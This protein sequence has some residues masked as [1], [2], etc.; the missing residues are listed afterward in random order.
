MIFAKIFASA[1]AARNSAFGRKETLAQIADIE[2]VTIGLRGQGGPAGGAD[3]FGF[4]HAKINDFL[5]IFTIKP[6]PRPVGWGSSK[7]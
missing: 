6:I 5:T 1:R 3:S 2:K 7:L 4:L